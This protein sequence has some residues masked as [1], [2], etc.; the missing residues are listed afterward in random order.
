MLYGPRPVL[1]HIRKHDK[2]NRQGRQNQIEGLSKLAI[3]VDQFQ[4]TA[5][6][7]L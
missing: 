1:F 6:C 7:I 3:Q 5:L 4:R 2:K